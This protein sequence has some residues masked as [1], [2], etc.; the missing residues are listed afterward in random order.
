[1]SDL[2]AYEKKVLIFTRMEDYVH[3]STPAAAAWVSSA[4]AEFGWQ[5][6]V[7]DDHKMLEKPSESDFDLI[8]F[9]NNSGRI[10]DPENEILSMHINAGKGVMGIHAALACFLNGEDA[11]GATIMQPTTPIFENIFKAH[12]MNHPPIQTGKVN[13]DRAVAVKL[14]LSLSDLPDSF[15][16]T[17]EFFNFTHNPCDNGDVNVLAYVDEATYTGGMMGHKH[18]VVW[19]HTVGE[20]RAPVFYCALGHLSHFYNGL[21]PKHVDTILR[22][23]LR[24]CC[25]A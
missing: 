24:Y 18:P 4:C 14:G 21:G 5:G 10:F 13:L 6:I 2:V 11:S 19:H 9:V 16:H 15:D 1:M 8:V 3:G 22:A 25:P 12:F 23:G 7:T 20:N 17:D